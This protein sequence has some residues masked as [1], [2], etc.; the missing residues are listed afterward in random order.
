[1]GSN[2]FGDVFTFT[3]WGESHGKMIGVVI[4]GCPSGVEISKEEINIALAERKPG[5]AF[6]SPRKEEDLCEIVSGIYQGKTTGAPLSILIKNQDV[7]SSKYEPIKDIFRPGHAQYTYFTK[8]GICD[9]YGGGRASARETACRV[10]AGTIAKKILIRESIEICAFLKSIS[11]FEADSDL[12]FAHLKEAKSQDPL[13]CPDPIA[14]KNMQ[15]FLKQLILEGESIGGCVEVH[16]TSIPVGLGDPVYEKLEANLGKALLSIPAVKGVVFGSEHDC[17]HMK[18]SLFRDPI[19]KKNGAMTFETNHA[20]GILGGISNG[21]P[22]KIRIFFKP[23]SSVAAPI[24]SLNTTFEKV[25]SYIPQGSRHDPC[26]AIRGVP[27][28]EAMVAI[29]LADAYLKHRLAR[30]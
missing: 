6:T 25:T 13:F 11:C 22:L 30:L 28:A 3:T 19:V 27:V 16:T 14:S 20:A 26:V 5:R 9:P 21:M 12:E 29:T 23:A 17:L 1:M 2:R 15:E 24:N 18:G 10:C 4:D 7:D 8:Y